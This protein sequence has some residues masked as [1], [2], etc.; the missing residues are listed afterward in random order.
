MFL[1]TDLIKTN[2]NHDTFLKKKSKIS[3]NHPFNSN[4]PMHAPANY[5]SPFA[6]EILSFYLPFST[7]FNCP[8]ANFR[9]LSRKKPHSFKVSHWLLAINSKIIRKFTMKLGH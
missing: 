9:L 3:K 8:T 6:K 2:K 4:A 1:K 7:Q 5:S